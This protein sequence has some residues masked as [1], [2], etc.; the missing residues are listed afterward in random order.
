MKRYRYNLNIA[1]R[2]F[3]PFWVAN[4]CVEENGELRCYDPR[5][6]TRYLFAC[7]LEAAPGLADVS[8]QALALGRHGNSVLVSWEESA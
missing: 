7:P 8:M 5:D 3:P 1:P 6:P 2:G 4:D